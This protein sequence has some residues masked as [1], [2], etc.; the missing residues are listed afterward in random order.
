MQTV[1][2]QR[3]PRH[4]EPDDDAG[5]YRGEVGVMPEG[6]PRV[7]V[8][9][10]KLDHS[11]TGP[12]DRVMQRDACVAV[13]TGV[14]N[15]AD[16]AAIMLSAPSVLNPLDQLTFVIRLPEVELPAEVSRGIPAGIR[17]I[18]QRR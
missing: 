18:G 9:D 7:N 12:D 11:Q 14:D 17:N 15:G 2:C 10:M 13:G 5:R 4:A 3:I 16:K 1:Q 8:G 6:F